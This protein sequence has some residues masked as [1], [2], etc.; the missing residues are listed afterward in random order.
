[1]LFYAD[2]GMVASSHPRWIQGAFNTLVGLFYRV[3]LR[4]NSGGIVGMV[5]HPYQAAGNLS[6]VAYMRRVTGVGPTYRERLKG[7]V[8][9]GGGGEMLAAGSLSS[10]VVTKHRREAEIRQQWSTTAAGIGPQTYRISFPAKG[11]PRKCPVAG[12][13]GRVATRSAVRVHVVHR[14][15]L[16]TAVIM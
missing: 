13:P 12:C 14:H 7:K 2:N 3:G 4:K 1:M 10:H 9:C 5:S 6:T 11:G 8:A 16:Y 15:V